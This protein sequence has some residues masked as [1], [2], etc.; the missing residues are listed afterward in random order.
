[1]TVAEVLAVLDK[2]IRQQKDGDALR[3]LQQLQDGVEARIVAKKIAVH[4]G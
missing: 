3:F 2:E 4:I 1:M